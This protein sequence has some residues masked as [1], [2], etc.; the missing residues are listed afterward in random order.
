MFRFLMVFAWMWAGVAGA[1]TSIFHKISVLR[2]AQEEMVTIQGGT[3]DLTHLGNRE[4]FHVN[5]NIQFIP[6][7]FVEARYM[8][9]AAFQQLL[10]EKKAIETPLRLKTNPDNMKGTDATYEDR[11]PERGG[12]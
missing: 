3:L 8:D 4:Y 6:N 12:P 2:F 10:V 5:G 9:E 7:E 11:W 1:D